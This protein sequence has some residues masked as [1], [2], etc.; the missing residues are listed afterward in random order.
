MILI[1]SWKKI[2]NKLI[3]NDLLVVEEKKTSSI[4]IIF[5]KH[6]DVLTH[7][8]GVGV[9]SA[10]VRTLACEGA[11]DVSADSVDAGARLTLIN[12]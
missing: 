1:R 8:D 12:V 5:Q 4:S 3:A 6:T 2:G 7:A 10:A 9:E 11:G